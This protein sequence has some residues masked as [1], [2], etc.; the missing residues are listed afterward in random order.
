MVNTALYAAVKRILLN[1]WYQAAFLVGIVLALFFPSISAEISLVDDRPMLDALLGADSLTLKGIFFPNSAGGGYYRPLVGLSFYLDR[2]LWLLDERMLHLENILLHLANSLLVFLIAREVISGERRNE[3]ILPLLAGI[4]FAVHPLATESV[5]WISGRTDLMAGL[6]VLS[7][8]LMLLKYRSRGKLPYLAS[9][10]ILLLLGVLSKEVAIALAVAAPFLLWPRERS[11]PSGLTPFSHL[12]LFLSLCAVSLAGAVF[13]GSYWVT[14]GAACIYFGVLFIRGPY[15]HGDRREVLL[16]ARLFLITTGLTV[17]GIVA[18]VGVRRL[19][20]SSDVGKFGQTLTLMAGDP[21]YA[22]SVF[23]GATGFYVKKFFLP[24]PLNLFIVEIDPL[25]DFIGIGV[26]L[27]C[28]ALAVRRTRAAGLALT[29]ICMLLPALPF[30]FGTIAWTSYAER[31]V[32][33]AS[34][35]WSTA[36]IV[37]CADL[38]RPEFLKGRLRPLPAVFFAMVILAFAWGTWDRNRVWQTNTALLADTVSQSPRG[39]TVR[40][41]YAY[42]LLLEK[43]VPEAHEQITIARTLYSL[44]YDETLDTVDAAIL[45]QQGKYDDAERCYLEA[46]RRTK[47]RSA[48][49]LGALISFYEGRVRDGKGSDGSVRK[50]IASYLAHLAELTGDP[51]HC[52][53]AGQ[54]LLSQS[55]RGTALLFFTKARDRFPASNPFKAYAARIANRLAHED[56]APV[57]IPASN[58]DASFTSHK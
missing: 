1:P 45:M 50:K 31:Y 51:Y 12:V 6:F 10:A 16:T 58:V 22:V 21:N 54:Y 26:L 53:R 37:W 56:C 27:G 18:A 55:D 14:I 32:Y 36:L 11:A 47:G 48:N 35:F 2:M 39:K 30:A 28:V 5:N 43:R 24:L 41:M 49:A 4:L 29:G 20:F 23:L 38:P 13:L 34:A 3:S 25:Y 40:I 42:A 44:N 7:A 57:R 52:Y 9:A 19:A 46:V 15:F 17:C 33:I 8:C